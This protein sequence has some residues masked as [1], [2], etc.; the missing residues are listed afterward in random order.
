MLRYHDEKI[1]YDDCASP[2]CLLDYDRLLSTVY[3]EPQVYKLSKLEVR[4]VFELAWENFRDSTNV[5][6]VEVNTEW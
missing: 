4:G 1:W 6:I 3:V 2:R 5:K